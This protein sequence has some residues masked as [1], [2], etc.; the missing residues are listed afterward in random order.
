VERLHVLVCKHINQQRRI[1]MNVTVKITG[2]DK[3]FGYHVI[4]DPS[5]MNEV[6]LTQ[7]LES[8]KK[9]IEQALGELK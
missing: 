1:E 5:V 6:S 3:L 8:I 9:E 7:M 4:Y 2:G